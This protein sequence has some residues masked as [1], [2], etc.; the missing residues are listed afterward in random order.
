MASAGPTLATK[1]EAW[2]ACVAMPD[3]SAHPLLGF[4]TYKVEV[5]P[6]SASSSTNTASRS[7]QEVIADALSS[8]YRMFDCA[9]FYENEAQIGAALRDSKVPREELFL[10]SKVWTNVIYEG[11]DAIRKQV[12]KTLTDLCTD[13]I[14]LYLIHWPVPGKHVAAYQTLE[15]LKAEGKLR[16]IGLSN[17]TIEDYEELKPHAK[18]PP[19]VNQIEINP[20]LY[21]KKTIEYFQGQGVVVQSYRTL[22]QAKELANPTIVAIATKHSRTPAQVL[23]RWCVQK[24]IVYIP[25]SE[26]KHRM[27]ENA[28]VFG[29]ELDAED[30][31]KLDAMTVPENLETFKTLYEKC[32]VRD[33]PLADSREGVKLNVTLD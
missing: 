4:G 18:V 5:V 24:N 11:A 28:D 29:F 1:P 9:Q 10:I 12:D 13:Y 21:R 23:G 8:G 14:D 15:A 26:K 20:F 22:R 25:K 31:A 27:E 7:A 17:Y 30:F 19:A 3:G 6:G 33:T 32:V 16:N 2:P